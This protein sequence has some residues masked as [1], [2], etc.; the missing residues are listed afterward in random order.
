MHEIVNI[1]KICSINV[2][3]I[4]NTGHIYMKIMCKKQLGNNSY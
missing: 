4:T 2:S 1:Y 3:I